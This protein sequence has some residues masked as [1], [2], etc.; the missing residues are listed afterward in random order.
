MVAEGRSITDA[1]PHDTA[2]SPAAARQRIQRSGLQSESESTRREDSRSFAYGVRQRRPSERLFYARRVMGFL[3]GQGR[4]PSSYPRLLKKNWLDL[5]RDGDSVLHCHS[6]LF[7]KR[8]SV[9]PYA[10][11]GEMQRDRCKLAGGVS[12]TPLIQEACGVPGACRNGCEYRC[13]KSR[14]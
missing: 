4:R 5:L 6:R 12:A 8:E 7:A 2:L 1:S 13:V 10:L 14:H 3:N 11:S 9:R